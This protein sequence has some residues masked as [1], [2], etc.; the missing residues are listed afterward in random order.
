MGDMVYY[1][2]SVDNTVYC[3]AADSGDIHWQFV[4]SGPIRLAP[5]VVDGRVYV[6]S[7]DGQV[8]CLN[9]HNGERIW[10]LRAGPRDERILARG[11][12]TSRW[13]VRT[14][15]LVDDGIAY[16]GAG[17]FP[18]ETVYLY[19]VNA[20]TGDVIWMND[21]ISQR[22]AGRDDLSPQGYLLATNERL[23][24]P[25]GRTLPAAFD[26]ATGEFLHKQKGGG[27]QIGG[28]DAQL[29]DDVILSVGE[30]YILALDQQA[31]DIKNRLR[32]HRMSL[33]GDRAYIADGE[34]IAAIDRAGFAQVDQ[35]RLQLEG[36]LADLQSQLLRHPAPTHLIRVREAQAALENGGKRRAVDDVDSSDA[37]QDEA[38]IVALQQK[39]AEA[40][41]TYEASRKQ[42][43]VLSDG[44]LG[45]QQQLDALT[46]DAVKWRTESAYDSSMILAGNVLVA[47]GAS[48]V[49]LFDTETGQILKT[50]SVDGEARPGRGPGTVVCQHDRRQSL[51]LC[52][53]D[54]FGSSVR[55]GRQRH[56]QDPYPKDALSDLYAAAAEQIIEH[57]GV[58]R[59]Y[60]LVVGSRQG[61]LAYELAKRTGLKI[62]CVDADPTQVDASRAA[63]ATTGLYGHR[64]TV[65]HMDLASYPY[66][67]FFANLIVS[68]ALL[69]SGSVPGDPAQVVRHLKPE[70]GVIC[71]GVPATASDD[72]KLRAAAEVLPW[73]SD[74]GLSSAAAEIRTVD[75]WTLLTRKALP[76]TSGWTHQYGNPGNTS[77]VQDDRIHGGV[78][79][80]W[81]GDPGPSAMTNRHEGAVGPVS[82]GGR[83]FIQGDDS[84]MAYDAFNGEFLWEQYN[85]EALR[86]G[87]FNNFEP[88]NLVASEQGVFMVTQD[89]CLH[90]DAAT[91]AI[92][93]TYRIPDQN[94]DDA[95]QWG[96][97][98]YADG[99]L[100][101]TST[102]R[103]MIAAEAR[104]RG[105]PAEA[106]NTDQ[107]FAIDVATGEFAWIHQGQ[108][109]AHTTIA[110]DNDRLYFVDSSL[111]LEQ[112]EDLLRQDKSELQSLTGEARVLAEE[113]IKRIDAR[114][115]VCLH[116]STGDVL[117]SQA[118]DVTDCTGVGIG[119]GRLTVMATDGHV[120]LCGANANGH[121]WKQFLEGEFKHRRLVVLSAETGEKRW[122][123]D[124]NYRHRPI[125]VGNRLIAEPWAFAL[126]TGE[127]LMRTHPLTGDADSLEVHSA[128]ASLRRDFGNSQLDVLPLRVHGILRFRNGRGHESFRRTSFGLLDQHDSGQRIGDDSRGQRRVRLPVFVDVDDRLRTAR[129]PAGLVGLYGG[130]SDE[131]RAAH[132]VEP[133]AHRRS[134]RR[135]W[136]AVAELPASV[137]ARR[138]RFATRYST[139]SRCSAS[140]VLMF[141]HNSESYPVRRRT[142]PGCSRREWSGMTR[143]ELP[144]ID[145]GQPPASYTVRLYFAALRRAISRDNASLMSACRA[146][147]YAS[148]WMSWSRRE[149]RERRSCWSSRSVP[150]TGHLAIELVPRSGMAG[151]RTCRRS[152]LSKCSAMVRRKLCNA[153]PTNRIRRSD[154]LRR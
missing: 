44:V 126:D 6:G 105:R 46:H 151:S 119:A 133:G 138:S 122:A 147:R 57:S 45:L 134:S 143:C 104:R 81:Y 144:L 69:Q 51:L 118:V 77:S 95:H 135:S 146:R 18:H 70:G 112:R 14:G 94:G 114:R 140:A 73:V 47:G 1:G 91:G 39:L 43:Q 125:V 13:P 98:A 142:C 106:S 41:A 68:D 87:V 137:V 129:K 84:V 75:G 123:R 90:M 149:R 102:V 34:R 20:E 48:K 55:S 109:I 79:V 131:A 21:E 9:A 42:Y 49:A 128:R 145:E 40:A 19:A 54:R 62:L 71:L 16:F 50:L 96:Y 61:R 53:G 60:C 58:T 11:R 5:T 99:L 76:G 2:S 15:V 93:R 148:V 139:A 92:I 136:Q 17:I 7:D 74:T 30:H 24:V 37:V 117:W 52:Q 31:G 100:F 3:V 97:V 152:A 86:T 66:P 108:S 116:T 59:G 83:L 101:G 12:M 113:R 27:K 103:E 141:Q 127:Q 82:V 67:N 72:V 4:T 120:V 153:W 150:V 33:D 36:E 85:P 88:G 29:V 35:Q 56:V 89:K 132:G 154:A 115:A 22:D 80:L 78:R 124:A 111:T 10:Q 32:A 63:L 64:I 110:I 38:K 107:I 25:S 28:S 8:Y 65:E 26:R 130:W 23:F 121:Y